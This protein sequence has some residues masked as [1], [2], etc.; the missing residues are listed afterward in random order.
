MPMNLGLG[1][2]LSR[3]AVSGA[4]PAFTPASL[5]ALGEQGAWFRPNNLST[6]W[7]ESTGRTVANAV[8]NPV[9]LVYSLAQGATLGPELISNGDFSNGTT[10]WTTETGGTLSVSSNNLVLDTTASFILF[11]Y[12]PAIATVA[13]RTYRVEIVVL[14]SNIGPTGTIR[15]G[16]FLA[17]NNLFNGAGILGNGAAIYS[18]VFT[19]TTATSFLWMETGFATS[20]Q[21]VI[22]SISCREVAGIHAFQPTAG[23]RPLLQQE[24]GPEAY[25]LDNV[26][27]DTLN[28]TAPA[29]TYTV[30]YVI[31]D[32]TVTILTSQSL[33]GATNIMLASQIVEYVAVNRALTG[34]ETSGLTAYL[35]GVANP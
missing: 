12:V 31:P 26:S 1:L 25:Y 33:S 20:G 19:A 13:G 4:A 27:S 32:G 6:M 23:D 10:N 15:V 9:G 7:Q 3:R 21:I 34:G 29:G 16:T 24:A 35:Q 22:D 17:A 28:W 5:F 11:N 14:S 18:F 2:G 30:A 8:S